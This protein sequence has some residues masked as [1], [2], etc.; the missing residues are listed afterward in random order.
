M[1]KALRGAV[2]FALVASGLP[3]LGRQR[4]RGDTL[5]LAYHNVVPDG[6]EAFGD[7]SLHLP[8]ARF[9]R[10]LAALSETH[11]VVGLEQ[12]ESAPSSSRPRAAITFDDA[13]AG[14]LLLGLPAALELGFP[15][16]I[17]VAPAQLGGGAMWWD[18]LADPAQGL[19][20][21]IRRHALETLRGDHDAIMSWADARGL[22]RR[23]P[24]PQ[25][26]LGTL[27]ELRVAARRPGVSIGLHTWSHRNLARLDAAEATAEFE[28]TRE[29]LTAN[30]GMPRPWLAYPYG[31]YA[32]ATLTAARAAG[33]TRAFRVDGGWTRTASA[34]PLVTPRL[35]VP[36]GMSERG[37]VLRLS[38]VIAA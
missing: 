17:F 36:A 37:F 3:A 2:E 30:V 21:A 4:R 34:G 6:L 35:N 9:R 15:A 16:T 31:R 22:P 23:L 29:W 1:R 28:R 8:L 20:E 38:G 26:R 32:D 18:L 24:P 13:Y 7:R 19:D 11:D 12:L 25:A 10:Q 14:A 5:V 33:V 27:D